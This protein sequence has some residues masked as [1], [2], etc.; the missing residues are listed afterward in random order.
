MGCVPPIP[1]HL[2]PRHLEQRTR[3]PFSSSSGSKPEGY[4]QSREDN[5]YTF[6]WKER[7]TQSSEDA[8]PPR[9]WG[10]TGDY[11][12]PACSSGVREPVAKSRKKQ[13]GVCKISLHPTQARAT[14]QQLIK[15]VA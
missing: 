5:E 9:A 2:W 4:C 10:D 13:N 8:K 15:T 1:L 12:A 6:L 14:K 7:V 3:Y 11:C